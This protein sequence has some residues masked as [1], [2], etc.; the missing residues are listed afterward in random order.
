MLGVTEKWLGTQLRS[1]RFRARKIGRRWAFTQSDLN[2]II[3]Q[4]A[5]GPPEPAPSPDSV[6]PAVRRVTSM[7]PTTARRMCRGDQS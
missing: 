7:T 4:C 1:G 5:V 6:N 3:R 2:E